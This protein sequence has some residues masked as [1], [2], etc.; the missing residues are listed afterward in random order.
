MRSVSAIVVTMA[1]ISCSTGL[2]EETTTTSSTTSSTTTTVQT[3]STA[4]APLPI[5]GQLVKLDWD[6]LEPVPGLDPIPFGSD[7]SSVVSDDGDW[8]VHVN[9]NEVTPIEVDPWSSTGTFD[10]S[11]HSARTIH[12]DLLYTYDGVSGVVRAVDLNTGEESMLGKWRTDLWM[13]DELHVMSSGLIVGL[14]GRQADDEVG[15][16]HWVFWLDLV[17]GE[18]GDIEVGQ[19]ERVEAET[20]VFDGDYEIEERDTPGVAWGNDRLYIAH[21]DGPDVT[22]VD[23]ATGELES[24]HL[25]LSSWLDRLLAFWMPA[26]TAKGPS[27]GTYS[28]VSLSPDG[29]Y[30]FISGNR[31]DVVTTEDGSLGEE[32]E[33]LGVVVVDVKTWEVVASSDLP[34]QFVRDAGDTTLAVDTKSVSPWVD[35]VYVLSMTEDGSFSYRGPVTTEG[36][37]CQPASQELRLICSEYGDITQRLRLVDLATSQVVQ[38]PEIGHEDYIQGDGVLVD[39][40]PLGR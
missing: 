8:I 31:Y 1:L 38:G 37:G 24:H 20:G 17:S 36:G 7:L 39:W 26:A 15:T 28:S 30:L 14:G 4:A 18:S 13:W 40:S 22:V 21:A 32:S 33:H 3:T 35:D 2:A 6:T 11:W 5:A 10:I 27:M 25:E 16:N 19:I 34:I 9:G 12:G 29:R 23:L